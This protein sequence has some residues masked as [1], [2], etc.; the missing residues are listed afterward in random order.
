M[1]FHLI[2]LPKQRRKNLNKKMLVFL[3]FLHFFCLGA[4]FS[5]FLHSVLDASFK[6]LKTHLRVN[7]SFSKIPAQG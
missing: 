3:L 1:Y 5:S 6:S 7:V 2:K 4:S